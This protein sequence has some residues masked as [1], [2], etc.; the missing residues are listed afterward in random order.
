MAWGNF[1]GINVYRGTNKFETPVHQKSK[2]SG[3]YT[4]YKSFTSTE[5]KSSLITILLY[6][7]FT[8]VSDYDKLHEEIEKLKLVLQ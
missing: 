8:I 5:Y 6:R 2:F 3:V 4:N 1:F 7:N